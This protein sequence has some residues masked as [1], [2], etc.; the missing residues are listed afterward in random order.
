MRFLTEILCL[1]SFWTAKV[2]LRER[3]VFRK[4]VRALPWRPTNTTPLGS[5]SASIEIY[6][7]L[8]STLAD[9]VQHISPKHDLL[10]KREMAVPIRISIGAHAQASYDRIPDDCTKA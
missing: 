4:K 5:A 1:E 8:G 9:H 3:V 2:T 7:I 10:M 6:H